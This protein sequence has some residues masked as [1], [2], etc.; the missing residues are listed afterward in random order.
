MYFF[1]TKGGV[2]LDFAPREHAKALTALWKIPR[3]WYLADNYITW[4]VARDLR[5]AYLIYVHFYSNDAC[6]EWTDKNA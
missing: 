5:L 1:K 6:F 4:A 3:P 2:F